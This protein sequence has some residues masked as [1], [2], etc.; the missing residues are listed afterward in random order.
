MAAALVTTILRFL[1]GEPLINLPA[2]FEFPVFEDDPDKNPKLPV[3]TLLMLI[4]LT[5]LLVV[6]FVHKRWIRR[7]RQSSEEHQPIAL[8][9]SA[10][11]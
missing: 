9:T 7:S 4:S 10:Q 2:A 1:I 11:N 5:T 6:S 8:M 3:K